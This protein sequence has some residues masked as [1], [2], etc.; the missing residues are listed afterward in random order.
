MSRLFEINFAKWK[1]PNF[2]RVTTFG[3]VFIAVSDH[4]RNSGIVHINL[5][6]TALKAFY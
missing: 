4:P 3:I 6:R 2:K 1:S 5:F